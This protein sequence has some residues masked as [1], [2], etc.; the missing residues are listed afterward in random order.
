[1]ST[2]KL[3]AASGGG[4]ISIKGPSSA[5]GDTDFLDTSGNVAIPG[6]QDVSSAERGKLDIYHTSTND[7]IN[8][9]HIRLWGPANNDARIEFGT[10]TNTGE[11]GYIMYNDGDEALYIGSRMATYGEVNI[12]T[13]MNDGDPTSNKRL[14]VDASG[15]VLIGTTVTA[16]GVDTGNNT[17]INL[18][19]TGRI[20]V[21]SDDHSEFAQI[22]GG[23]MIRFRYGYTD[24]TTQTDAGSIDITGTNSTAYNTSSDY[25]LKENQVAI[26]DGITRLK[27]LKPYRFNFKSEKSKTVDGFFA[28]EVTPAVPEAITG[29]KDGERMQGIDQSK[30]VP[31]LTAALQEA[32]AKIET[33]ETKV[34]ALE[35]G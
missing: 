15:N 13:G 12:C 32:I 17:G 29:E 25:R 28:H 3:P 33:L 16:L 34:A 27:K 11:G 7:G 9:P 20:Y 23:E 1:M 2:L 26:S 14:I 19:P 35:A 6:T 8:S 10:A 18:I 22:G 24:G 31:L 5:S 21:K 30:L 4:S